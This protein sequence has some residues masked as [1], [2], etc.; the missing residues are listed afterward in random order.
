M[1]QLRNCPLVRGLLLLALVTTVA[2]R[3]DGEEGPLPYEYGVDTP[4]ST[5]DPAS[6]CP[7]DAPTL[8]QV[9]ATTHEQFTLTWTSNG[10]ESYVDDY[11][12]FVIPDDILSMLVAVEHGSE[13]TAINN[14]AIDAARF[15]DL[16][17]AIG[18]APFYHW[19]VAVASVAMPISAQTRP[20][21]GCLALDPVVY[22]DAPGQTGALHI[23]TR[24]GASVPSLID[25]NVFVVGDT[26]LADA[27]VM[28]A[29]AHMGEVYD[30]G[31]AAGI[32]SVAFSTIDWADPYVDSEGSEADEVR[33][34]A[35]AD[36]P[37][38][39]N[40][41]FVQDF[42]EVGTL[43]IAAGTPGPNGVGGTVASAVMVSVDTHLDG[44]GVTLLTDL[45]GETMAHEIGHQLG[46]FHTTEAEGLD[47]DG[48]SDTPD[49]GVENDADGDGEM[50]AEE[51][52]ALDGR[53]FMF[54]TS[55]YDFGQFEMSP[56]QAMVLRD[57]VIARP[58]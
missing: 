19:P 23:V 28:A 41:L 14:M 54:W 48:I 17:N 47:H 16:P 12:Y 25:V 1:S 56:V 7:I 58:L 50:T 44:D 2:C 32:G 34:L 18:E 26:L 33:A 43:G 11:L 22:A 42:N 45:L 57:S 27:D 15:V 29:L 35:I 53:N 24:R 10:Y 40:V 13:Y 3:G 4:A 20:S 51:C 36:N 46:L 5:H 49:C 9:D 39:L 55:A 6:T 37:D 8:G 30:G 52:E 21:G 31:G 38:A